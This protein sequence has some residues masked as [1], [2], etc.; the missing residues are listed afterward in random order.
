VSTAPYYYNG[1]AATQ[2][3]IE[4]AESKSTTVGTTVTVPAATYCWN[5]T[6]T[7]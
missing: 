2:A 5:M 4:E 3:I 1:K 6:Y 7:L